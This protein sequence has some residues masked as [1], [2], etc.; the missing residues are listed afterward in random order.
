MRHSKGKSIQCL[1]HIVSSFTKF[2][3]I[4]IL[5]DQCVLVFVTRVGNFIR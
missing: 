4:S 1:F 3:A 2:P 5:I